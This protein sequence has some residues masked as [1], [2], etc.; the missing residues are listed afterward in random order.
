ML[1]VTTKKYL[2]FMKTDPVELTVVRQGL[3]FKPEKA[4][5]CKICTNTFAKIYMFKL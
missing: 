4:S 3:V 5:C 2:K 1:A